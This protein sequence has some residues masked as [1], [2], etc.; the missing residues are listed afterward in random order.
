MAFCA[1]SET[2]KSDSAQQHGP[3]SRQPTK[4]CT[5]YFSLVFFYRQ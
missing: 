1:L 5:P 4:H 2:G 3:H